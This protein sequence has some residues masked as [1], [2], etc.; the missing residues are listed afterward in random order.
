[1]SVTQG[2][3][4]FASEYNSL[5][6][7]IDKWFADNYD[8]AVFGDTNQSYGWGGADSTAVL[9]TDDMLASQM[10]SLID[11]CNVGVDICNNVISSLSQL[12]AGTSDILANQYNN[13]ETK[14]DLIS[15]HR[16]DI[17]STE[18]SLNA[19]QLDARTTSYSAAINCTFRYAFTNFKNS[20]YFWNTNGGLN[21]SGVISGYTSG[22]GYDGAGINEIFTT[23]GTIT[24][25]HTA[26]IQSGSGG[27]P[28][29][30]G[31][32]DLTTAYQTIFSQSGTGAYTD[33]TVTIGARR[34]ALGSYIELQVTITP[35]SG[36]VV[37]GTTTMTTQY[38]KLDNQSSGGVTLIIPTPV[39]TVQDTLE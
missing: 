23:M 33:A 35:E 1:M 32:Y 5:R 9:A 7:E 24:M 20:R 28:S 21:I 38:R 26:T 10:N 16:L 15:L 6:V 34:D 27:S 22:L 19:G 36:R 8:S 11:R 2:F 39:A 12:V 13:I 18:L 25:N 14:S 37:D 31:F 4:A 29:S 17:V 30:I 3:E